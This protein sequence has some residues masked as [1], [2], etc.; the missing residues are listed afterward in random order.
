MQIIGTIGGKTLHYHATNEDIWFQTSKK[1][2]M[3]EN[4]WTRIWLTTITED[5][6]YNLKEEIKL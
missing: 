1:K 3:E 5:F 2:R 4:I 6:T